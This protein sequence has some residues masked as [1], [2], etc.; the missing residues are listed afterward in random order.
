VP[1]RPSH[2]RGPGASPVDLTITELAAGGDGVGRLDGKV[3][4]VAGTAPGERVRARVIEDHA[5]WARG[6]LVEV[7]APSRHRIAPRC[8]LAAD[9][10][11]GGCPWQHV[12]RPTQLEAKA[13]VVANALRKAVAAGLLIQPIRAVTPDHGWRRRARLTWARGSGPRATIGFHGPRSTKIVDV[14]T[15]PQLEPALD[16]ALAAVRRLAPALGQGGE[17]HLALGQRDEIHV[18][19]EG[20]C[21][22]SGAQALLGQ[23]GIVGVTIDFGGKRI[24]FGAT[25]IE[26]DEA[27]AGAAD[28]FAQASEPGNRALG[29]EVRVALGAGA[30]RTLLELYAGA[31]NLTR[32][33]RALG[34]QVTASDLIAPARPLEGV[35]HLIGRAPEVL[36]AL[37]GRRF[38]AVLI[39]PPRT[40][41]RDI[42]ERLA[43]LGERIVY[44]SCD[45]ATLARDAQVLIDQ[46]WM[47]V[48]AVPF[49]LMPDTA[50][51]EVVLVL[52]GPV[53][54]RHR[55]PAPPAPDPE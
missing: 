46:G 30:D 7:M 35:E 37:G 51:V 31:G 36:A 18:V 25:A 34:W 15:C 42:I 1:P 21:E 6:E 16:R 23:A 9:R 41:A 55:K 22:R 40:G 11:C 26:I 3:V 45:P 49:D 39:D 8:P 33:A 48:R 54:T 38:D 4:F 53:R 10:S 52:E 47:P 29:Q 32:H 13:T 28:A 43:V 12:A 19:I 44:V 5:G 27:I 14:A 24:G 2:P 50:H 17:L 20:P